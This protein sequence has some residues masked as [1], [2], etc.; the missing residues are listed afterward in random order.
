MK[1]ILKPAQKKLGTLELPVWAITKAH[2]D[3]RKFKIRFWHSCPRLSIASF[4]FLV[5]HY[6][7]QAFP[8]WGEFLSSSQ[9][10][11]Q[12]SFWDGVALPASLCWGIIPSTWSLQKAGAA[13][14]ISSSL[15]PFIVKWVVKGPTNMGFL[16][17]SRKQVASD[18]V[19]CSQ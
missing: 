11:P 4:F 2:G 5:N 19:I 9:T 6:Q 7:I 14:S 8:P 18:L 1:E 17:I 3:S 12:C 13:L 15:F 10:L 16:R